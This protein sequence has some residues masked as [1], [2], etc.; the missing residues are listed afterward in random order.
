MSGLL[1]YIICFFLASVLVAGC[2]KD[3]LITDSSAKLEFSLDTVVFDTVFTTIGSTTH[4]LKVYNRNSETILISSIR[5]AGGSG[6]P[7]RINV[8]GLPGSTFTEIEIAGKDS[9]YIFIEVT[10]NPTSGFLPFIVK[11]SIVFET[12]GNIQDVD[13]VVWGQDAHFFNGSI[14]CDMTWVNDKPYVIYNSILVDSGC[15]LTI[16]PGVKV[17]SHTNSAIYVYGTLVVN[18]GNSEHVVF[19]GDR[20]ESYFDDVTGQWLGI[21]LLRGSTNNFFDHTD[22]RNAFYGIS[23]GSS[24]SSDL[25][26]FTFANAPDVLIR[27]SIISN[28]LYTGI[29]GFLS[30]ITVENTLVYNCG[31]HVAH[32]A[33][34]GVYNFNHVTMASYSNSI[35]NHSEAILELGNFAETSQ[36][37]YSADINATFTN[38]II[39]GSLDDELVYDDD[40][41][42]AFDFQFDN[43]MLK[44]K[45]S[46]SDSN[47]TFVILNKNPIYILSSEFNFHISSNSPARDAGVATTVLDDIEENPRAGFPDIG[48]YEYIP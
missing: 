8:D 32:L 46:A 12:N 14:I 29:F 36:G 7:F 38:C 44:T 19:Q 41:I 15:T 22:I 27:R 13:L 45:K 3:K 17:Y 43:C 16:E 35:V 25:G 10:I 30:F 34:G 47:Y 2:K 24:T 33:F 37:H 1:K 42:A 11:D 23:V 39:D 21:F 20:T 40:E 9:L 4:Q 28:M 48:A 18:G 26:T 6:S 31:Q 5:V